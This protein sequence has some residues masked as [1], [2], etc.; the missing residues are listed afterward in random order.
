MPES[1]QPTDGV[2]ECQKTQIA[3][4]RSLRMR[5]LACA[6]HEL[7]KS[8]K[9]ITLKRFRQNNIYSESR[10]SGTPHNTPGHPIIP[11]NTL[12]TARDTPR[13]P[14]IVVSGQTAHA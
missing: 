4:T 12:E 11:R 8:G 14:N 3:I 2:T 1:S 5:L 10:V 13:A 7:K 6:H 9:E